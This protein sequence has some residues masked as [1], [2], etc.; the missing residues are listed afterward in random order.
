M[1]KHETALGK[2]C[3][4]CGEYMKVK[5][6]RYECASPV[7]QKHLK[8]T[9]DISV[10]NDVT[11]HHP[12][13]YCR[14]CNDVTCTKKVAIKSNK[15]FTNMKKVFSAWGPHTEVA[16]SVC[17]HF[18]L[19]SKG[20]RPKKLK[21]TGRPPLIGYRSA[22]T[23]TRE[24]TPPTLLPL[25][26]K[27]DLNTMETET[28]KELKCPMCRN[29]VDQPIELST[30]GNIV[31]SECLVSSLEST[32]SL[33]CPLCEDDHLKDFKTIRAASSLVMNVLKQLRV[34]CKSCLS[35][36]SLVDYIPHNNSWMQAV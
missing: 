2:I 6:R 16:C 4:V 36:V 7:H 22:V 20:G 13:F 24:I 23:H 11:S 1:K 19:L 3:R 27:L 28:A 33:V 31:C 18:D 32:C 10:E 15:I 34:H 26:T 5:D 21:S 14:G 9:F 17:D 30:C 25:D 12:K 35:A 8:Y 29:V